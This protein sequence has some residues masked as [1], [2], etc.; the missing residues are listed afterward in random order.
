M[1]SNNQMRQVKQLL[2]GHNLNKIPF[3]D[4]WW[5]IRYY[6]GKLILSALYIFVVGDGF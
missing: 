3:P 4:L 5:V 1:P 6:G 2:N